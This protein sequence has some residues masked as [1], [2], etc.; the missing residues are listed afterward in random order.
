MQTD[1][2]DLGSRFARNLEQFDA[3]LRN[4]EAGSLVDLVDGVRQEG[5]V[6]SDGGRALAPL[7]RYRSDSNHI[8]RETG[9]G[10]RGHCETLEDG[11][12]TGCMLGCNCGVLEQCYP[13]YSLADGKAEVGT[14]GINWLKTRVNVG[15][16]G[17]K[18]LV[19]V[20]ES[21]VILAALLGCVVLGRIC[22]QPDEDLI[23]L[24][25]Y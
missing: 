11:D 2:S 21:T 15:I 1:A 6:S 14:K 4:M 16:C 18:V 22:L 9:D 13:K 17:K 23:K 12:R 10:R 3:N 24:D 20:L 7:V 5:N 19:M 25:L 8:E